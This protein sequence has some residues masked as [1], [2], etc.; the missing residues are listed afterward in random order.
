MTENLVLL[1]NLPPESSKL[2]ENKSYTN[3]FKKFFHSSLPGQ[4]NKL[5]TKP[6]PSLFA[7]LVCRKRLEPRPC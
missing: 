4:Q 5:Q 6:E 1:Q 7:E 2:K 3:F